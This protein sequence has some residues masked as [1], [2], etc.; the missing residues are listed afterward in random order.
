M[1]A[2]T[3]LALFDV[4]GTLLPGPSCERRF[5]MQLLRAGILHPRQLAS[6]LAFAARYWPVHGR[7]VF[8]KDKAYLVDLPVPD[9][10][11]LAE[12]FVAEKLMP[13]LYDDVRKRLD[14]HLAAGDW[15]ALLT[16]APD[17]IA[18]PLA[19]Q[20]GVAHVYAT[21]CARRG[22]RFVMAPPVSHPFGYEKLALARRLSVTSGIAL[23]QASAYADSAHDLALLQVVGRPV[24]VYPD[25]ALRARAVHKQ[26]EMIEEDAGLPSL[27]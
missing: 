16:G 18:R 6:H 4:D 3:T 23:E 20:L 17:F 11:A 1:V 14:G 13:L 2:E 15:V 25:R 12:R 22:G 24:A 10:E 9:I 5:I 19:A 8:K 21:R 27:S 26:W 7:H